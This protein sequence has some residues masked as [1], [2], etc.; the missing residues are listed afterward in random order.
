MNKRTLVFNDTEV[1]KKDF[2]TSKQAIP[3][4]LVDVNDIIISRRIK[5]TNDTCKHF[6]CYLSDDVISPLCV[7]LPQMSGYVKCFENGGKNMSFK[8]EDED[9]YLKYNEISNKIKD[10]LNTKFH[11]QPFYDDKYIKAKVKIV[12]STINTLFSREKIPKERI[13]YVCISAI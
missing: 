9:V 8:I 1:N 13:H 3:L 10:M 11:S 7:I 12:N 6:I 5:N 4:N 2:Y